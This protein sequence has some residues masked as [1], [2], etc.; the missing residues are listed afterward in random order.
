MKELYRVCIIEDNPRDA[1][2]LT[3][4]I[5]SYGEKYNC[6][7]HISHYNSIENFTVTYT[8]SYDIIF[9][10]IELPGKNGMEGAKSLR[11]IDEEVTILFVTNL[12]KYAVEG[13]QVRAYDYI[14]KPIVYERF[15]VKLHRV[16]WELSRKKKKFVLAKGIWGSRK[17]AVDDIIYIE[18][19]VHTLSYHLADGELI[20][21][22][23][24]LGTLERELFSFG[25]IRVS[26]SYLLNMKHISNV[27][28]N[29]VTLVTGEQFVIARSRN[30]EFRD[31]FMRYISAV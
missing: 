17:M 30:N 18:V 29:K 19:M 10:D 11:K 3:E 6:M 4:A 25:F 15:A 28:G 1:E 31:R 26:R 8:G 13:Y 16:L 20:E 5:N 24:K 27:K 14:L 7:F 21:V 2:M 9:F 12:A 23:G 22:T